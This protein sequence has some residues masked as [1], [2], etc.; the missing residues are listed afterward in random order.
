MAEWLKDERC[1]LPKADFIIYFELETLL[2]KPAKLC[3]SFFR[4]IILNNSVA[5]VKFEQVNA[6]WLLFGLDT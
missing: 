5:I 2:N 4:K 6:G 1:L 3:N